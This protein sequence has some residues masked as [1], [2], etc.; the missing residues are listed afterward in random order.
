VGPAEPFLVWLS[1]QQAAVAVRVGGPGELSRAVGALRLPGPCPVVAVIGGAG[2]LGG[3]LLERLGAVFAGTI[4]PAIRVHGAIAVDGGTDSGVMR[5]LGR[6]RAAGDPFPL[7]GVAA[8]D[9]VRF[10]GHQ[11]GNPDAAGLEPNHSHFVF[12]PGHHWGDEATPLARVA[13]ALAGGQPSVTVLVN[14][15]EV[16]LDDAA[17]S[18]A[19]R[20]P[21]LVL[22][23]TGRTADRIAA[24][25]ANPAGHHDARAT[26]IARSPL[27]RIVPVTD[28][29]AALNAAL[30]RLPE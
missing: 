5:L 17:R 2:G 4:A 10:P 21:L 11:G 28:A 14:G 15:G 18:I 3:E 27:V 9:T 8:I 29:T 12:V 26:E 19:E 25:A 20:R 6:A 13:S 7:V 1:D 16:T 30:T 22:A 24:A 23:G